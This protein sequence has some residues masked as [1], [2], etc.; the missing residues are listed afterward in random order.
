MT[1][2]IIILAG[3]INQSH[4]RVRTGQGA[5][6]KGRGGRAGCWQ[7]RCTSISAR[8]KCQILASI[9]P[10]SVQHPS[11]KTSCQSSMFPL[12]REKKLTK[13]TLIND[14]SLF[15]LHASKAA[16]YEFTANRKASWLSSWK[17]CLSGHQSLNCNEWF[18]RDA[19]VSAHWWFAT[20]WFISNECKAQVSHWQFIFF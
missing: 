10:L 8:I 20:N 18:W 19:L 15:E 7:V 11:R 9:C 13:H 1:I 12:L 3:R 16:K 17:D 4:A 5:G 14:G 2:I 6:V